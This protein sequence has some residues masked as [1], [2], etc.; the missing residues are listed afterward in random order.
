MTLAFEKA[1]GTRSDRNEGYKSPRS[2]PTDV[3]WRE[4]YEKR[5][6]LVWAAAIVLP[7]VVVGVG[8]YVDPY[9]FWDRFL[10]EDIWGPTVVDAESWVGGCWGPDG[11]HQANRVLNPTTQRYEVSCPGSE[12]LAKDG[13]TPTSEVT[14]GLIL[15]AILYGVWR[16]LLR[17]GRV[18]TDGWFVAGLLPYIFFG[19]TIRALED[20]RVF[21]RQE[22][23]GAGAFSYIFISPWIYIQIGLYAIA[24]LTLGVWLRERRA[25][26]TPLERVAV[27]A[28]ATGL[29]ASVHAFA[30][31][32][33]RAEFLVVPHPMW[34]IAGAALGTILFALIDRRGGRTDAAVTFA[35]GLPI[36]A[37]AIGLLYGWSAD[38][39]SALP[40]G[41]HYKVAGYVLAFSAGI[42]AI[43][44]LVGRFAAARIPQAAAFA[45]G[46][47]AAIVFGH[48]MDG[49]ATFLT[50]CS[51]P[52]DEICTGA[53]V[54]NL[55]LG[56]YGEKHPLSAFLLGLFNG[57][58]FPITKLLM[59]LVVIGLLDKE[60]R[61]G[62]EADRQLVGLIQMAIFVLG[63]GPGLRD[64]L[65]VTFNLG[66]A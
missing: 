11:A 8:L 46:I 2:F 7:I 29:V 60:I 50:L 18:R 65:L 16:G 39:W 3:T 62:S 23:T 57:W 14:Y 38:P 43:V 15:A 24:A 28:A 61:E 66:S 59:V 54:F 1:R 12:V 22:G 55:G 10:W 17:D 48:M 63:F 36:V 4:T 6:P 53:S 64:L 13:Y 5:A 27:V 26:T 47:N 56:G 42:T 9:T 20:A 45:L 32:G 31:N 19:P 58:G 35:I 41:Y 25:V 49:F 33:L 21:A 44:W 30:V 40:P 34:S 52:D 51:A 37:P